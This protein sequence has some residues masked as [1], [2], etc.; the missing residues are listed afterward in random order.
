[1][2]EST[3][4]GYSTWEHLETEYVWCQRETSNNEEYWAAPIW[5]YFKDWSN[6]TFCWTENLLALDEDNA[7]LWCKSLI[8]AI[9]L[10]FQSRHFYLDRILHLWSV[11]RLLDWNLPARNQRLTPKNAHKPWFEDMKRLNL[12]T[13]ACWGGWSSWILRIKSKYLFTVAV[14]LGYLYLCICVFVYLCICVFVYMCSNQSCIMS[15]IR[16]IYLCKILE[17]DIRAFDIG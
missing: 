1:M 4:L 15:Q 9:L 10:W 2:H 12:D 14:Q 17:S 8:S 5:D 16:Q 3:S 11:Y 7:I 13:H 6:P